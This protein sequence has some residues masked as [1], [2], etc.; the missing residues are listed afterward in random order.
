MVVGRLEAAIGG[1]RPRPFEGTSA[2]AKDWEDFK[3]KVEA[4]LGPSGFMKFLEVDHTAPGW[5]L[6][7]SR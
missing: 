3:Q 6:M 2:K 1:S 5:R 4:Q 7:E